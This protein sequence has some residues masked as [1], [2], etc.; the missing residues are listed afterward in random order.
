MRISYY[1]IV[2]G[3]NGRRWADYKEIPESTPLS[4]IVTE[5]NRLNNDD[6]DYVY[7][8]VTRRRK[9]S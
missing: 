2:R 3:V 5:L 6:K 8:I 4:E 7:K 9:C 1:V